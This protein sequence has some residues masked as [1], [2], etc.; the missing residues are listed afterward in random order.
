MKLSLI[1]FITGFLSIIANAQEDSIRNNYIL[2]SNTGHGVSFAYPSAWDSSWV[3]KNRKMYRLDFGA[4]IYPAFKNNKTGG[5]FTLKYTRYKASSIDL[6]LV[7]TEN[8]LALKSVYPEATIIDSGKTVADNGLHYA[9]LLS[10]MKQSGIRRTSYTA[11]F[12][13]GNM[14]VTLSLFCPSDGFEI[15]KPYYAEILNHFT[16]KE[17]EILISNPAVK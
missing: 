15:L 6:G 2:Y 5:M 3:M 8:A 4:L 16:L 11:F 7:V 10:S 9:F 14:L 17:P 1:L 13:R 12:N